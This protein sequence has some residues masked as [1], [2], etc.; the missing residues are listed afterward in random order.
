[1]AL[2]ARLHHVS[3]LLQ[4]R[5]AV[6]ASEFG[7]NLAEGDVLFTLRRAGEPYRLSPTQLAAHQ[8]VATGTMTG[9]LDRLEKRGL[10]R[11]IPHPTDRRA[12]EVELT[13]EGLRMVDEVISVHVAREQ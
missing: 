9:R 7:V 6:L 12:L 10:V 8:L 13:A 1:M 3:R 4:E 2:I 5:I 11:R